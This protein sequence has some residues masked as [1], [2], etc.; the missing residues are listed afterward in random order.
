[1]AIADNK[2]TTA[3]VNQL[4]V[5]GVPGDR[6]TG[7]VQENKAVFDALPEL[8]V[9]RHNSLTDDMVSQATTLAGL[10]TAVHSAAI[11]DAVKTQYRNMGWTD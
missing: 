6:L 4:H 8:L 9:E 1:M 7:T 10:Y 5:Q 2:I 11:T 3:E